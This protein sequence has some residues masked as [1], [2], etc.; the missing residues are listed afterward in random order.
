MIRRPASSMKISRP[1]MRS[2]MCRGTCP[3]RKPGRAMSRDTF[4]AARLTASANSG[5]SAGYF[6]PNLALRQSLYGQFHGGL[7]PFCAPTPGSDLGV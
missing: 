3:L 2:I 1:Y 5:S 7:C 4:L 6:E